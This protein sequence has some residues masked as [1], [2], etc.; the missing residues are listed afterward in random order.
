LIVRTLSGFGAT[1]CLKNDQP[2]WCDL[3][4]LRHNPQAIL[5]SINSKKDGITTMATNEAFAAKLDKLLKQIPGDASLAD[6]QLAY[7]E[8]IFQMGL[9]IMQ[10]FEAGAIGNCGPSLTAKS[11]G[12]GGTGGNPSI[13]RTVC[14]PCEFLHLPAFVLAMQT[15]PVAPKRPKK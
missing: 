9:K 13:A 3:R 1:D 14:D 11:T 7:R 2:R 6:W 4:N 10:N 8:V 12:G 15:P 5:G